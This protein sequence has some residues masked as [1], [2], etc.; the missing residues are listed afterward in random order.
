[1]KKEFFSLKKWILG[2]TIYLPFC[3]CHAED[4]YELQTEKQRH[5]NLQ[6]DMMA[7][8][9][10]AFMSYEIVEQRTDELLTKIQNSAFGKYAEKVAAVIPL[11]TG[12]LEF[13]WKQ[14][15]VSYSHFS[16][17]AKVDYHLDQRWKLFYNHKDNSDGPDDRSGLNYTRRF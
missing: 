6:N 16:E 4:L 17:K 12:K 7:R 3:C 13:K 11:V 10:K 1:M 14:L 9:Q 2:L 8:T 15:D 5:D